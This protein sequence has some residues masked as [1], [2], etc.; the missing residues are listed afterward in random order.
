[1]PVFRFVRALLLVV[2]PLACRD[3]APARPAASALQDDWGSEIRITTPP[4]QRIVS[5]NPA[6]TEI[7]FAIGAGP[8]VVGR[9]KYD[10]FLAAARAVADLGPALRPNVEAILG[11]RPDL[12]VLYASAENQP[13][14]ERLRQAAVPVVGLRFDRI[15]E[16]ERDTRLLG[17]LTGDSARAATLVDTVAATLARVRAATSALPKPRV[18]MHAWE[19]PL[20]AIG[21]GSF[22]SQ[23]LDIAGARN[24][25]GDVRDPST[26]VTI[27][28][29]IRRDPDLVLVSPAAAPLL[30]ASERWQA[31]P[32]VRAGHLLVYDTLL[33]GRPGVTLGAAAVSLARSI[34]PGSVP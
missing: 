28:D 7:L 13:A 26:V 24:V 22:L 3:A 1:M 14:A 11:A 2:A 4:P 5:L 19:R 9:S 34:H 10:E 21:G 27:E 20:I 33:V 29:V 18:F 23:L 12:V 30:R 15:E 17:R 25:Y 8:R 32:A 6:T 16:F 31:V